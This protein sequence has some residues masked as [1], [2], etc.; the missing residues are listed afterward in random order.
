M[1]G[2]LLAGG[3]T[4]AL[5]GCGAGHSARPA[6][7]ASPPT[8]T[9]VAGPTASATQRAAGPVSA[10][11][12]G[13]LLSAADLGAGWSATR[14]QQVPCHAVVDADA[15][16]STAMRESRGTLTE[17]LSTGTA[18]ERAVAAWRGALTRCG[19]AV[20]DDPLGDAGLHARSQDGADGV[21]VTG[22]EGVLIVL[23]AHGRLAAA[24][25]ELDSWADLA[26][27]TSCV[28]APDGCH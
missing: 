16:R 13:A 25:D 15:S 27:G 11:P 19:W 4:L 22:T 1:R 23:H 8:T 20:R 3:L 21:V 10:V 5:A 12:A 6:P 24:Q 17:T 14:Q 2:L 26:L 7:V 28:A 18:V 9:P